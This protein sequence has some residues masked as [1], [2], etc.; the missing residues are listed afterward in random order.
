MPLPAWVRSPWCAKRQTPKVTGCY[1]SEPNKPRQVRFE[2][3]EALA[4]ASFAGEIHV[5]FFDGPDGAKPL[6]WGGGSGFLL[7]MWLGGLGD[8]YCCG[9]RLTVSPLLAGTPPPQ[10]GNK[11]E[12]IGRNEGA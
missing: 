8:C 5:L 4:E 11:G 6:G 7:V 3:R 12:D 10:C 2:S 1:R 9:W